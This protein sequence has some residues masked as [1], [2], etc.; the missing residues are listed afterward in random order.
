MV[1][2][3]L[4]Y[5]SRVTHPRLSVLVPTIS[6]GA[7]LPFLLGDLAGLRVDHEVIVADGGSEDDT[8]QI[9]IAH[10]ARVVTGPRGR[11]VQLATA[12]QD[13]R[14]PVLFAV[15]ADVRLP[16]RTLRAIDAFA[17]A[18]G[19]AALAFSLAIDDA[20]LA[21]QLI[22]AGANARSRL[23]GLPY[24]DQGLLMTRT[25]YDAIG[26]YSPVPIME[27]VIIARA[28]RRTAGISI[29][30]EKVVVSSRRWRR[31]GA[32]RRTARNAG[33]LLAFLAGVSPGR[34]S[35]WY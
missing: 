2:P 9:A 4:T 31:D 18:P 34:I 14:A 5:T 26:G 21:F 20:G 27:D 8:R 7:T 25:T 22:A 15:H 13:A 10:G 3:D 24:G 19:S 35:R 6:E 1:S 23:L 32:F 11:G 33:L 16:V 30:P 28:L 12:A 29:S 17:E